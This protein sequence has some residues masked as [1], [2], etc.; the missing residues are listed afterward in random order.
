MVAPNEE[1]AIDVLPEN[2]FSRG[3]TASAGANRA[4]LTQ[5][6]AP[7]LKPCKSPYHDGPELLTY[8]EQHAFRDQPV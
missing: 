7:I 6:D 1:G 5:V 3:F 4:A 8:G 2:F